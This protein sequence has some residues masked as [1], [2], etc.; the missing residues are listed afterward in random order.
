[1]ESTIGAFLRSRRDRIRPE[2]VGLPPAGGLRRVPGLRR[3]EVALVAGVSPDYYVRL[4]QGRTAHVSDQVLDAVARALSLSDVEAEHLRNLARPEAVL[5]RGH[6]TTASRVA[7]ADASLRR[8]LDSMA[9][10]PALLL[11]VR[12]DI[13]A[14][15]HAAEAVFGVEAMD[16][17]RN[18]ARELFLN[19]NARA[20]YSDW[21]AIALQT[22]AQLRLSTGRWP[23]DARLTTLVGELAIRSPEFRH[24]WASGDVQEKRGGMVRIAHPVVGTLEFDYHALTVAADATRSL[25]T[26][27]PRPTTETAASL[28]MLLSWTAESSAVRTGAPPR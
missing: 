20:L 15:N 25:F 6:P 14:A 26:Y 5:E 2:S 27:V 9:D 17:P 24:M 19:P 18:A 8:L 7:P 11:D 10:A 3:E 28:A 23:N 4:E 12:L 21:Q 13:L 16:A 22:V 1:M